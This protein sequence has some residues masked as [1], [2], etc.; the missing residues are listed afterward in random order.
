MMISKFHI[1]VEM[2]YLIQYICLLVSSKCNMKCKYCF[3]QDKLDVNITT[4]EA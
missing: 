4:D 3:I 1:R 2:N